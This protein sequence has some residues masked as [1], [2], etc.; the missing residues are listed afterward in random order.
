MA[1]ISGYTR[2][3]EHFAKQGPVGAEE[4]RAILNT[5]FNSQSNIIHENGGDI[6]RYV[7][8]G[9]LALWL[10]PPWS[11]EPFDSVCMRAVQCAVEMQETLNDYET[12]G[13]VNLRLHIGLGVGKV[14]IMIVG[15]ELGWECLVGGEPLCKIATSVDEA[16]PGETVVDRDGWELVKHNCFGT[17]LP[18]G[19]VRVESMR[20]K[21]ARVVS[22][23]PITLSMESAIRSYVPS[24]IQEPLDANLTNFMAELR[25]VSVLF[26]SFP[27]IEYA[28]GQASL[29]IVQTIWQT[30][31]RSVYNLE[32]FIKEFSVDDKGSVMVAA[33]GIPPQAHEDDPLRAIS[34]AM[35]IV[36][37]A[38]NMGLSCSAGVTT[39]SY[40]DL[41]NF[42]N[43]Y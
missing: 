40:M 39:G 35:E 36:E 19:A 38:K 34:A 37:A 2:L 24:R 29:H 14:V 23:I 27:G 25:R 32:G 7:G 21:H 1:D 22:H 33:F 26:V 6:I 4:I 18:S 13:G 8:D 20:Q 10:N 28:E 41:V 3:T 16:K 43:P 11:F 31:Q 30:M 15:G 12:A 17:V 5:Y 9:L 42:L